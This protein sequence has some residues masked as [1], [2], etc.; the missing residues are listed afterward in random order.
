MGGRPQDGGR[1]DVKHFT[2]AEAE[3]LIPELEAVFARAVRLRDQAEARAASLRRLDEA[4]DEPAKAALERGQLEFL[5]NA[6][7]ACLAEVAALGAVAKGLEPALVDFPHR[8]GDDEVY[9][10][11]KVGEKAI[12]HYHGTDEG[13]AGRKSLP[14]RRHA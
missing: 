3:A 2:L 9:L 12:T 13:F 6:V 8:L 1:P 7:N 5:V 14:G 10:C 11:W 4:G